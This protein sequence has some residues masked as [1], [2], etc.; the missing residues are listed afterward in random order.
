[1]IR[2]DD[3]QFEGL[4]LYQDT[5][6]YC[7]SE[8]AVLLANFVR[9]SPN[10]RAMDLGTGNGVVAILAAK[11]TSAH[12]YGVDIQQ[13]QIQL[14]QCSAEEN[15]QNI[16]FYTMRNQ[17]A[18]SF[19]GHGSFDCVVMNPPYFK[20]GDK[21]TNESRKK[22][23]HAIEDRD[24]N[25]FLEVASKLLRYGGKAYIIYP[26]F[27]LTDLFYGM[28][29][30]GIEPKRIQFYRNRVLVEGKKGGRPGLILEQREN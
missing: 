15:G 19:F 18:V 26:V 22:S 10:S 2:K 29:E 13:D 14:A 24:L 27:S 23:K 21:S 25:V 1:M 20:S 8:D 16:A 28:R 7:F 17:E 30:N 5:D 3:L 9:I 11:K 6:K 4:I 12:F